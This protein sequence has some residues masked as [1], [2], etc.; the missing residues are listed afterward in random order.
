MNTQYIPKNKR[1]LNNYKIKQIPLENIKIGE[2]MSF[3]LNLS[4]T[5]DSLDQTIKAYKYFLKKY[6]KPYLQFELYFEFSA[7]GRLH[8]HGIVVFPSAQAIILWFNNIT[9]IKSLSSYEMDTITD[10]QKWM[11]YCLKQQLIIETDNSLHRLTHLDIKN[12]EA[13]HL[14]D[15]ILDSLHMEEEGI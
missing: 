7:L 15:I 1:Y 13:V 3:S 2:F 5:Y 14:R 4:D 12:E 10:M 9:I 8:M 11:T 6:I